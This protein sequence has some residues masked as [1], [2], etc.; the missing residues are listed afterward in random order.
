[1]SF[2]VQ[3][4]QYVL[5]A[6][7]LTTETAPELDLASVDFFGSALPRPSG[8]SDAVFAQLII[9]SLFKSAATRPA[10]AAAL[11][12]LTGQAP[13]MLEPWNIFDT[14]VWGRTSYWNVDTLA[15]PA[16]WAPTGLQYQGFVETI[17]AAVPAIGPNNPIYC[18]GSG[19]LGPYW[20]VPGYFFATI[21]ANP[22]RSV[23][24]VINELKAEGTTVWV[25]LVG[26]APPSGTIVAPGV[27][28]TIVVGAI[29][30][31][32]IALSWTAPTVGTPPFSYLVQYRVTGTTAWQIGPLSS[33]T[34]AV[35]GG[36]AA[37]TA[38]DLTV[39][40]QNSAG[41]ATSVI[42][43]GTTPAVPPGPATNLTATLVQATAVTLLW[44][45]PTVGTPPFSYVVQYRILGTI[46]W[47]TFTVGAG[48]IGVT[49][50]GLL[51]ATTYQF[52]VLST[53]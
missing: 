45:A 9:D 12:K 16:R 48:T 15:N 14:G 1:L 47:S 13:R 25:K 46:P 43:H 44:S 8:M 37:R 49:V 21:A 30:S 7:R 42:V 38:Y 50:I 29:T 20:N 33:I 11:Q 39:T 18:W 4:L 26:G 19:P 5:A 2:L 10:I 6:T 31:S 27:P 24:D 41:L 40:A 3:Q 23:Y 53:N 52:E 28:T 22:G 35:V 17:P 34:S 51:P 32:S 36:L